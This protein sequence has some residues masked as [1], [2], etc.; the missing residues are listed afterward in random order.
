MKL[1]PCMVVKLGK[2]LRFHGA[3]REDLEYL[4][5][6]LGGAIAVFRHATGKK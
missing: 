6:Q 5:A 3:V 2:S 1:H 4:K